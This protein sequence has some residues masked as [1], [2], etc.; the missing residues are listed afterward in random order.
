M[1]FLTQIN[2]VNELYCNLF[3]RQNFVKETVQ[4]QLFTGPKPQ[5]RRTVFFQISSLIIN[6]TKEDML[7][8]LSNTQL[9]KMYLFY[10]YK[11]CLFIFSAAANK[12]DKPRQVLMFT[13][14]L[15]MSSDKMV[16]DLKIHQ[17]KSSLS[18]N[19]YYYSKFKLHQDIRGW[20][21]SMT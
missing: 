12:V 7:I 1:N 13:S 9:V 5:R 19:G 6:I 15:V 21:L 16:C 14:S 11:I 17:T 20:G 4:K 2:Y 10:I 3:N 18:I 8:L